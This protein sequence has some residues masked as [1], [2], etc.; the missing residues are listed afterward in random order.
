MMLCATVTRASEMLHISQPAT[1]RLLAD[2]EISLGFAL[3]KREKKRLHPTAEAQA[4]FEEV[5]RSLSGMDRIA[6][7]AE[8]IRALQRGTLQIVAAPAL[9]HSFLPHATTDYLKSHSGA[10]ISLL[11]HS[12]RTVVDMVVG[13]RC[14]V[15][16]AIL[17]MDQPSAHGERLVSTKM[18]CALPSGHRLA[19]RSHIE[20]KDLAGEQLIAYPRELE[21]RLELD[22]LFASH[23]VSLGVQIETQVSYVVCSFV[24]AG[25]GVAIIDAMTA[26]SYRGNGVVFRPFDSSV[27]TH[28]SVLIPSHRPPA[29]LLPSFVAHVR[30]YALAKLD[31]RLVIA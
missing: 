15:G 26:I 7:A 18:V 11:A 27:V 31:P 4:L 25:A 30:A 19:S 22:A 1:T 8:E 29:L 9:A 16:F 6:R 10:H 3:F 17:R 14:D 28:F 24:E 13:Q 12:S 20:P 2:L 21:S 23:G 5:Q